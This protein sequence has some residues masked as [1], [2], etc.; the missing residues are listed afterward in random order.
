MP[1]RSSNRDILY[2]SLSL[3]V[4]PSS[5]NNQ[6][7]RARGS[8]KCPFNGRSLQRTRRHSGLTCT[9]LSRK[10]YGVIKSTKP[11]LCSL[12][13]DNQSPRAFLFAFSFSCFA[14]DTLGVHIALRSVHARI[15]YAINLYW[16]V[17]SLWCFLRELVLIIA[18]IPAPP[19]GS[20]PLSYRTLRG[21]CTSCHATPHG[22]L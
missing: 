9:M 19:P 16:S 14:H 2:F 10:R 12:W 22:L 15:N 20:V 17:G 5:S 18:V 21:P 1:F 4:R 3:I 13:R 7:L 8:I 6:R 11:S